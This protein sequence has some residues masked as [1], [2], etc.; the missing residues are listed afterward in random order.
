MVKVAKSGPNAGWRILADALTGT[1]ESFTNSNGTFRGTGHFSGGPTGYLP[2]A[3]ARELT[4]DADAG[5]VRFVIYSY[6]T[7]IAWLTEQPNGDQQWVFPDVTY[8]VTT[9]AH[10]SKLGTVLHQVVGDTVHTTLR[11]SE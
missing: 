11:E 3:W 6:A 2:P 9:S 4:Q 7:P 5:L 10:Q 8:S 1:P